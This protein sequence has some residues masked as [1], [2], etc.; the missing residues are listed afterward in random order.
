MSRTTLVFLYIILFFFSY[1]NVEAQIN[2]QE[3]QSLISV[4]KEVEV[5]YNVQFSYADANLK[6]KT[7]LRPAKKLSLQELL[8]YLEINTNLVFESLNDNIIV[9]KKSKKSTPFRTQLL[10]EVILVNYLTKGIS[11]KNDGT[12]K[13]KPSV[14]GILP[15]LTEPD[16]LHA[17]QALPGIQSV[18]ERVSNVNIRGG[19]H[20]QNLI[21]W[22]G[23][24]MYQSG[25]F[26]GLISA[27]N[28]YLTQ[29]VIVSKNGTN[30][31]YGDGVSSIIDMR[32][33]NTISKD[34][35]G[36]AG[37]NLIN[38][39]AFAKI[40]LNKKTELQ[41][42][43]RRSLTD[44]IAT[45]TYDQYFKRIF[46]DTDFTNNQ[47]NSNS[48]SK[49]ERFYFYDFTAKLLY[50]ISKKDKLR[51]NFLNIFNNLNY[52]EQSTINNIN[53]VLKSKLTQRNLATSVEYKRVWSSSF[54]TLAQVYFSNYNLGAT[55]FD[56]INNQ[57]LIQE[58]EVYDNGLKIH[59]NY[60]FNDTMFLNGG[61]QF[62][63]VGISNLQD[64][65]NPVFRSNIKEVLRTHAVFNEIKF[66][67]NSHN[68]NARI[69]I[70]VNYLNKFSKTLI[71]PRLSF[72][73]RF[74]NHFHLELLGELKSQTTSQ[75][76]DLQNDFLGIEKRR[77][78]LA[79]DNSIPIIKSKQIS[80]G[81]HFNK[82][83]LTVSIETYIKQVDGITTR[84]QGFQNQFQFVNAIGNYQIKGVDFLIN[85]QYN[86]VST[87]FS[88][89]YSKNDYTFATLLNTKFPNNVDT[90]HA[91]NFAGT[92]TI[93]KFKFA[94]G[95]NWRTGKPFTEP[96]T[97]TPIINNFINYQ[98]P[99]NSNIDDYLRTDFSSTYTFK[100]GDNS[101]A[102]AGISLW[103]VLNRSN[104]INTY[105]TIDDDNT[106]SKVE[107][108]SLGITPNFSFRVQF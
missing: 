100:I 28:P 74:L 1:L 102:I 56:I 91:F 47:N 18:D 70:R 61:Y 85:K 63:E 83:N 6:G 48:I 12:T 52:K 46:Q 40:P 15:G 82:N 54:S 36:G 3:K 65:N 95:L 87:W 84:S 9:I 51:V 66:L 67:S 45:P 89:S 49:N 99:N 8:S 43:A 104:I 88:Y 10:D 64:L 19:T 5:Q 16:I 34:F 62:T 25:H 97:N 90:R 93:S 35:S 29:D 92:Y 86:N 30:A 31:M 60:H 103:N 98:S 22:D 69:G 81:I 55:N 4:L 27:F 107:N 78:I 13:L 23:I 41:F 17:I 24:K 42:S 53:E 32:S 37:F 94:L 21:L 108:F 39:D 101:N 96:D 26:F 72:N 77:W 14:L 105:Y 68:T 75:I 2:K 79:N 7:I 59:Y 11:L 20:D 38:A 106:I 76:I 58:N 44:L 57:R 50:D 80:A 33:S 73:Q 71:E